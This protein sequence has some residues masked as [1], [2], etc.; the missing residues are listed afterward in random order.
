MTHARNLACLIAGAALLA[1][2]S[3]PA[4]SGAAG[5]AAPGA[6]AAAGAGSSSSSS[7]LPS[8][9]VGMWE[10]HMAHTTGAGEAH[11]GVTQQCMSAE[12]E[13]EAKKMA[14]D[15]TKA[16]CSRNETTGGG[17][18]WVTEMVCKTGASTMTTHSVTVLTG[19]DAY[20]TEMTTS[21]DPPL[22]G[23]AQNTTTMDGKWIGPCKPA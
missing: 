9:K 19:E 8:L 21:F 12:A 22:A 3:K 20:H 11:S 10:I 7:E 2:C 14:A 23:S 17:G 6:P 18:R 1:A 16:N 5:T 13:A 4:G 15:Y